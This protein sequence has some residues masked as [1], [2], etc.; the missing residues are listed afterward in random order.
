MSFT[1]TVNNDSNHTLTFSKN[2]LARQNESNVAVT[3]TVPAAVY[4]L[5]NFAYID[6]LL[7]DG[8]R[9]YKGSYD[10]SSGSF[11]FTLGSVDTILEQDGKIGI[12]FVLRDAELAPT[13][14]WKSELKYALVA[15]SANAT[16][17]VLTPVIPPLTFPASFP[18]AT[19]SITDAGTYFAA[20]DVEDALQEVGADIVALTADKLNATSYT[21]ADVLTKVK[22]VDGTGSGLDADLLDGLHSTSLIGI[23]G[24]CISSDTFTYASATTITIPAGGSSRWQKGDKLRFSQ[25]ASTK[26]FYIIAV[27][28]TLLTVVGDGAVVVENTA[29]YPITAIYFS[30]I[31]RPFSFPVWFSYTPTYGGE[32][33]MTFTETTSQIKRFCLHGKHCI[34][35]LSSGGTTGGSASTY[36]TAT[37]PIAC[38]SAT[39]NV[40]GGGA[41]AYDTAFIGGFWTNVNATT[42]GIHKY[43][44]ANWGIGVGMYFA[45]NMSYEIP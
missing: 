24:W 10:P 39:A 29:T 13:E 5:G 28:D 41:F 34:L 30:R 44:N 26:Y 19:T 16:S 22:T 45:V 33:S 21:A 40:Y 3:V 23:D 14:V 36:I 7:P 43:N 9:Y 6:F 27:A 8:T 25:H 18:A 31:M 2:T 1:V 20:T 4:A 42:I 35:D 11:T 17:H 15:T 37:L 12:Q 38:T 32:G